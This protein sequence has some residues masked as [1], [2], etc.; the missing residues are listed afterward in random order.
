M[1][2]LSLLYRVREPLKKTENPPLV[3]MLH[4]YGADMNDLFTF[5]A[6]LPETALVISAQAPH[7]LPWGGYAWWP[8]EMGPDGK[9]KRDV[10]QARKAVVQVQEFI[11]EVAKEF[12]FDTDRFFLLGFSQGGMMSYGLALADPER[13][14]GVMALSSYLLDGLSDS[15]PTA[16]SPLPPFFVSHG[17]QDQVLPVEGARESRARLESWGA[18]VEYH[19]YPMP[20]GINPDNLNDLLKWL[21]ARL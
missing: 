18:E 7:R 2:K 1:I 14:A 4:G 13:Y 15:V 12:E 16:R 6:E 8:L 17:T 3:L 11:S 9:L 10:V 5:A 21:N 19:E 20:H